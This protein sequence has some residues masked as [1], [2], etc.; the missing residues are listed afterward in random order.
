LLKP[1]KVVCKKQS[2]VLDCEY[3]VV[4]ETLFSTLNFVECCARRCIL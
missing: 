3:V 2:K 1:V 4:S